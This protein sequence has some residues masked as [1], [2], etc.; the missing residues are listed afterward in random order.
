M[1]EFET[2]TSPLAEIETFYETRS[3]AI[4]QLA[5]LEYRIRT[6]GGEAI[7]AA[8]NIAE[9]RVHEINKVGEQQGWLSAQLTD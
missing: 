4:D 5:A 2:P 8:Y 9:R 6:V 7:V 3:Q 1:A